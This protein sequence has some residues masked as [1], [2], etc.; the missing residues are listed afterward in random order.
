VTFLKW[1]LRASKS[2]QDSQL[3]QVMRFGF[4]TEN[5]ELHPRYEPSNHG[6]RLLGKKEAASVY[7]MQLRIKTECC[8]FISLNCIDFNQLLCEYRNLL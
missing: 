8:S 1:E 7:F 2:G 6:H 3:Q 4:G 5:P